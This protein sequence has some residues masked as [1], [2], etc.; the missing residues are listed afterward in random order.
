MTKPSTF[1]HDTQPQEFY[2]SYND[3]IIS[4]DLKVL[5]KLY[6]KMRFIELTRD[7]P[8]DIVELGVFKGS[9]LFAWIKLNALCT[10]N[11]KRVYGFDIFDEVK[12][13]NTLSDLQREMMDN[14][15]KQRSFSHNQSNYKEIL[16]V[17]L[18]EF[19]FNNAEL[20]SGDVT[21]TIP[22]FL[23][24]NPGFRASIINFDLDVDEPTFACLEAMWDRL[25]KGGVA[26]F[27]EYAINKWDE[28]NAVDRF[29][30]NKNVKLIS[31]GFAA[32]TAYIIK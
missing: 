20:I 6:S 31:T 17:L 12:L 26:I 21:L 1:I 8:G 24:N 18:R 28:S 32:P 27:D 2:D 22:N 15:F 5:S 19:G 14:L 30:E 23:Q 7:V 29:F 11:S 3:F 13:S 4:N 9:G 10:V 25:A 16:D